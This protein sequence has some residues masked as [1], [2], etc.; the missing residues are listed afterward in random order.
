M[1]K[2]GTRLRVAARL[3]RADDGYITWSG[4]YDR[5]FDDILMVQDEIA[6]EVTKALM[7]TI[8]SGPDLDGLDE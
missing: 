7:A 5:L 6:A 8:T 4:T 2:S 3:V 1:R